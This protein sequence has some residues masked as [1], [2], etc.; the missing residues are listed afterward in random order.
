MSQPGCRTFRLLDPD[1]Y[2]PRREA[3]C[4]AA[5]ALPRPRNIRQPAA[6]FYHL[7]EFVLVGV[8]FRREY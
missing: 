6:N 3:V 5:F 7:G 1:D 8:P 4:D 2:Q